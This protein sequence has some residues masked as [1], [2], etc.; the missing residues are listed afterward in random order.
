MTAP[1]HSHPVTHPYAKIH[2]DLGRAARW[3]EHGFILFAI[4]MFS[5]AVEGLLLQ[6]AEGIAGPIA[7]LGYVL[8]YLG[9][10]V[11]LMPHARFVLR[12]IWHAWAAWL[13]VILAFVS[14]TWSVA[15]D[16]TIKKSVA[17]MGSMLFVYMLSVRY[18]FIQIIRYLSVISA[19][20]GFLSLLL[21]A[22]VPAIGVM[23]VEVPGAWSGVWM[24]KNTLGGMMA[25]GGFFAMIGASFDKRFRRYYFAL[26]LLCLF[27]IIVSWSKTSLLLFC[28]A[29][30]SVIGIRALQNS[31]LAGLLA[32]YGG[33]IGGSVL[34]FLMIFSPHLLFK[35]IG[36][37]PS[38]TGRTPIW[39]A[40]YEVIDRHPMLGYG[41]GAFW[42]NPETGP[43]YFIQRA[44]LWEVLS[45]HQGWLEVWLQV[46]KV[47][48]ILIA[49]YLASSFVLGLLRLRRDL[50]S[51]FTLPYIVLMVLYCFSESVLMIQNNLV[52]MG[53]VLATI[54]IWRH[55]FMRSDVPGAPPF[56]PPAQSRN[57]D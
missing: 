54:Y 14:V 20:T 44:V 50:M 41:Y 47:G 39:Q 46:G 15:P 10:L 19:L 3:A 6:T 24:H 4:L 43:G 37:D 26:V 30:G 29:I 25:F 56:L 53:L 34:G 27:M 33:V 22:L 8:C 12:D 35:A 55:T 5:G 32:I 2:A 48:V 7:Q 52:W 11:L 16:A 57:P 31:M 40:I 18:P 21:G 13:M 23:Q 49:I 38:F 28:L 51:S 42:E 45:A 9:A 1:S 36:K 17:L